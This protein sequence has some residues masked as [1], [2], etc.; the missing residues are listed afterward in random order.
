M[1]LIQE[2]QND[3]FIVLVKNY[4][5]FKKVYKFTIMENH[6]RMRILTKFPAEIQNISIYMVE[7]KKKSLQMPKWYLN[8]FTQYSS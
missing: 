7:F 6:K 3:C 2:H 1:I 5:M 8:K 4:I